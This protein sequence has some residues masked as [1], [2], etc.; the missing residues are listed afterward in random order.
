MDKNRLAVDEWE[1]R[2]ARKIEALA[3]ETDYFE[4]DYPDPA[5]D[6]RGH[7]FNGGRTFFDLNPR[8]RLD[9]MYALS[10]ER[11]EDDPEGECGAEV[12]AMAVHNA[13]FADAE[14]EGHHPEAHGDPIGVDSDNRQYFACGNDLRV[15][16]W[17]KPKA[18]AFTQPAWG[19]VCV[20]LKETMAFAD[21]LKGGKRNSKDYLLWE[22]LTETHLPPH[23]AALEREDRAKR[24]EQKAAEDAEKRR[25][26]KEAYES[27]D[28]KRSG[29]IAQKAAEEEERRRLDEEAAAKREAARAAAAAK[30]DARQ[31]ACWRWMLLPPRLRP[32][33]V[34]EGMNPAHS[35]AAAR[36]ECARRAFAAAAAS[37]PRGDA[38]VGKRLDVYW[39]DDQTW[40]RGVVRA[41]D[42]EKN[43][44][45]VY[46]P[47]DEVAETVRLA[48]VRKRWIP[49]G[50]DESEGA[51]P[52][53]EVIEPGLEHRG[54]KVDGSVTV[55]FMREPGGVGRRRR[56]EE[57]EDVDEDD[58]P[59][60]HS[61][62]RSADETM[63]IER[64]EGSMDGYDN[65]GYDNDGYDEDGYDEDGND[66]GDGYDGYSGVDELK[67]E[68]KAERGGD[69]GSRKNAWD[70]VE[71][72]AEAP[73]P[74]AKRS[75]SEEEEEEEEVVEE[76]RRRPGPVGVNE[77]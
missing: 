6:V 30:E 22:Y 17:E 76:E 48:A 40:Y 71:S 63:D 57:E 65:D 33:E 35:E 23:V 18:N 26:A 53:P 36:S 59:E 32:A 75:R 9:V 2:L 16:R 24:A 70:A 31:R 12:R 34:P 69:R 61:S 56:E 28:R 77:F 38:C 68:L 55:L 7:P 49:D 43:T 27:V 20:G 72:A 52:P 42:P 10:E 74:P 4:S 21:S 14:E 62:D 5:D 64:R 47:E 46:Y 66:D 37:N 13:T 19:T 39:D 15:Y 1:A 60:P 8:E 29:R 50:W 58:A 45:E 73:P 25:L 44:H 3:E 51:P 11:L 67:A 41:H 54:V